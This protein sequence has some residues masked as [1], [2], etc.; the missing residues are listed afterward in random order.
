MLKRLCRHV[1]YANL[2]S[3]LALFIGLSGT[4][5]A[6]ATITGADV[7]DE[8]LTGADIR[9]AGPSADKAATPGSLTTY[10]IKDLTLRGQDIYSD[11]ITGPKVK[12][13][14]LTG[15]DIEESTLDVVPWSTYANT[16]GTASPPT[17][18][19][20]RYIGDAG[21]PAFENGWTNYDASLSHQQA[22][23]QHVAYSK[24]ALGFVHLTGLLKG[25]TIGQ[26]M[27]RLPGA[28]CPWYYHAFGAISNNA[29]ARLTVAWVNVDNNCLVYAD[30][31]SNA[32]V[33]LDGISF[34]SWPLASRA[35]SIAGPSKSPAA[36]APPE[37]TKPADIR[38]MT[39]D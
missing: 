29:P 31:G 30:T 28:Y 21:E 3:S 9:G 19:R 7:V 34:Q 22:T 33:S 24:D 15:A 39:I 20:W 1:T 11:T 14:S 26:V 8:S 37:G 4:A 18:E 32:W 16:A 36:P 27:F 10:D 6:V 5:Y 35:E 17:I 23:Y 25:G 2:V 13:G 38:R 12:D